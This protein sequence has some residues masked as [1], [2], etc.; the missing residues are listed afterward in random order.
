MRFPSMENDQTAKLHDLLKSFSTAMLVTHSSKGELRARPMAIVEVETSCRIWFISSD[1]SAKIHE[2]EKDTQVLVT[3]QD[4]EK[5]HVSLSGVAHLEKDR[6]RIEHVWKESFKVW[7]P[8]GKTD[9][10]IVLIGVE[11]TEAEY[12]D[13]R[14]LN[15][16]KYLGKAASA[17]LKKET[18]KVTE[19][20][21]HGRIVN[22]P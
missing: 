20:E 11:F 2:I 12:W 18:P 5:A 21:E 8:E 19:G 9:P 14:G 16:V 1:E 22:L 3:C 4:G 10:Q 6:A 15:A 13:N 17:L 7:F